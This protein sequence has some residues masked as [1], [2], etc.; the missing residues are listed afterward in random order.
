MP[1][2]IIEIMRL[3]PDKLSK[4]T[5]TFFDT[6][7]GRA[8]PKA[9]QA[10]RVAPDQ[11]TIPPLSERTPFTGFEPGPGSR[12]FSYGPWDPKDL[13]RQLPPGPA[14]DDVRDSRERRR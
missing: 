2:D 10:A 5:T 1:D 4:T 6:L 3:F 11:I 13:R 8:G 7:T 9:K 12:S 14:A